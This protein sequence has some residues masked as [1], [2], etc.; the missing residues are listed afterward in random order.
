MTVPGTQVTVLPACTPPVIEVPDV[1]A[2]AVL[3]TTRAS[4]VEL[5][6]PASLAA[7]TVQVRPC[8]ASER[9]TT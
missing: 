7:S 5:A 3:P 6:V 9:F 8:R 4:D 1:N 2:G